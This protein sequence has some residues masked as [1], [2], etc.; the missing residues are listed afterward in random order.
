MDEDHGGGQDP[1]RVVAP[2]QNK[3]KIS[4][5]LLHICEAPSSILG[6]DTSY[7]KIFFERGGKVP[8]NKLCFK[9]LKLDHSASFNILP[10]LCITILHSFRARLYIG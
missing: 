6:P 4:E 1:R 8:R 3:N 2:V 7:P 10:N 9:C 5:L